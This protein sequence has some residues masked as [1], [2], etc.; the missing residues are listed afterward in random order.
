MAGYVQIFNSPA[1][2]RI[3]LQ[4]ARCTSTMTILRTPNLRTVGA[5]SVNNRRILTGPG[6]EPYDF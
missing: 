2:E 5:P 6:V 1:K 3:L 4:C